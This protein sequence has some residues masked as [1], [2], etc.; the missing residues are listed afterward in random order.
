MKPLVL[1]PAGSL[2]PKDKERLTK[3]GYLALEVADPSSVIMPN[4]ETN[5]LTLTCLE[6]IRDASSDGPRSSLGRI[7]INKEIA[8]H[9]KSQ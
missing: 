3:E 4:P 7:L 2:T 6:I 8:K 1:F 9:K 5:D